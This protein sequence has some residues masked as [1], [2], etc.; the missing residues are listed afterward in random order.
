MAYTQY[1]VKEPS[2]LVKHLST[3]NTVLL[4]PPSPQMEY[5]APTFAPDSH[6]LY[7]LRYDAS[8]EVQE[9]YRVPVT[10]GTP[11]HVLARL[12]SPVAVSPD[13]QQ[14]AFIQFNRPQKESA[15]LVTRLDGSH[16]RRLITRQEP[17]KLFVG[18]PAWSPDGS[19]L[20]YAAGAARSAN[21]YQLYEI[22]TAGGIERRLTADLWTFVF[23]VAWLKD[24]SGLILLADNPQTFVWHLALPEGRK[25]RL[26]TEFV[27]ELAGFIH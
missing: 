25:R 11:Q 17:A 13:G 5:H 21:D 10:G 4:V 3:Q 7:F 22:P 16:E 15:R 26:T 12:D 23:D 19:S 14:L 9:L 6:T 8:R 18:R 2:L 24:R 20:A 1:E 27:S